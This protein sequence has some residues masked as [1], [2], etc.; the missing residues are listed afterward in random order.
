MTPTTHDENPMIERGPVLNQKPTFLSEALAGRSTRS[1]FDDWVSAWHESE[2]GIEI[3]DYLGLTEVE[4]ALAATDARN[5]TRILESHGWTS[6]DV[7][8]TGVFQIRHDVGSTS[9][10]SGFQNATMTSIDGMAVSISVEAPTGLDY[11][12]TAVVNDLLRAVS[13]RLVDVGCRVEIQIGV[14]ENKHDENLAVERIHA[15]RNGR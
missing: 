7:L 13:R 8:D 12:Q 15:L 4:Y 10:E 14:D 9:Q 1:D 11:R 5:L 3:H 2:E 6:P